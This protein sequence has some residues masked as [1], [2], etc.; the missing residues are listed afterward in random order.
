MAD[1]NILSFFHMKPAFHVALEVFNR[2]PVFTGKINI[3]ENNI[4]FFI[5]VGML[6]YVC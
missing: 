4:V 3:S 1:G 2:R 6:R 5:A